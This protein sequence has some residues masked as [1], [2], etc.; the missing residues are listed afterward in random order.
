[1]VKKKSVNLMLRFWLL[2]AEEKIWGTIH[3]T[4]FFFEVWDHIEKINLAFVINV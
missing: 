1:M 3:F 4:Y 2:S